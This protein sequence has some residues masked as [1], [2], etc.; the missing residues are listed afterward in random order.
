MKQLGGMWSKKVTNNIQDPYNQSLTLR[1]VFRT[2]VVSFTKEVNSWFAKR[3]FVLTNG[4][5]ANR[6]P[7]FLSNERG[8]WSA[9]SDMDNLIQTSTVQ[10]LKLVNG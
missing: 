6:K 7:Y 10:S 1:L 9:A 8:H 2:I 4:R 3:P 5:L